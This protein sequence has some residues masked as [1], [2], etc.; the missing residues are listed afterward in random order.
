MRKKIGA[1]ALALFVAAA[2]G[3]GTEEG[4][5]CKWDRRAGEFVCR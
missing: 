3:G 1:A 2:W 4:G 5:R